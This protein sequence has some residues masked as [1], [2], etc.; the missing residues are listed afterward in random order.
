M[1]FKLNIINPIIFVLFL[2]GNSFCLAGDITIF[3]AASLT[4][5]A[6]NI[7][8]QFEKETGIKCKFNFASSGQLARQ[9]EAG[10]PADLYLS[11]NISWLK[12]LIEQKL[13][14]S[15]NS[16][17][18][19]GNRLVFISPKAHKKLKLELKKEF[20]LLNQFEGRLVI[21]DPGHVPAGKYAQE[22]LSKLKWF[23]PLKKRLLFCSSVREALRI[24][25]L[26]EWNL[27]IVYL[28]DAKQ[29]KKIQIQ[30]YFPEE[31]HTKIR[32]GAAIINTENT[33]AQ[34]FYK[35][36]SSEQTKS[37]LKNYYFQIIKETEE[38]LK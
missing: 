2:I 32:Y 6:K 27:G 38:Y 11:A 29:S 3:A 1:K 4:N 8:Q 37:I 15:E 19:A 34:K 18:F 7:G 10:A 30:K 26:G 33:S 12:Y 24:I 17:L 21:G 20:N 14:S 25:E 36:L 23:A 28:S 35:F 5:A 16:K 31:L 9:I 22:A 13:I